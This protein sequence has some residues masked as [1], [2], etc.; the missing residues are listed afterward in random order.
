MTFDRHR[1]RTWV[2]TGAAAVGIAVGAAGI[3]NAATT[4]SSST[5]SSGSGNPPAASA[6]DPATVAHGPNETLLTGTTADKVR[7]AATAAEPG[8]TIIRVET[9]SAGS[10]YEAHVRKAD[11]TEVTLKID[12]NFKVTSTENGFGGG[13]GGAGGAGGPHAGDPAGAYGSG[14]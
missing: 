14:A 10:P 8:A 7:A 4:G 1:L 2:L 3:A 6:P 11:G 5:P 13:P 12:A 9:D